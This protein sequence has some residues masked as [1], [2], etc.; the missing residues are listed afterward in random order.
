MYYKHI[1][2]DKYKQKKNNLPFPLSADNFDAFSDSILKD[3]S[4]SSNN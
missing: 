1:C 4:D 3:M 2:L